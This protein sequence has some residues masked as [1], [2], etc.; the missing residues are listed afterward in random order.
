[1]SFNFIERKKKKK[2]LGV[3]QREVAWG[4]P[5][6]LS[7]M[8]AFTRKWVILKLDKCEPIDTFCQITVGLYLFAVTLVTMSIW[9]IAGNYTQREEVS[10]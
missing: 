7:E 1:M 10:V 4:E 3:I 5:V 6:L 8:I 9:K 2:Q